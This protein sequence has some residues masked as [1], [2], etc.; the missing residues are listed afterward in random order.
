[1]KDY[2]EFQMFSEGSSVVTKTGIKMNPRV[3]NKT[4]FIYAYEV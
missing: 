3:R 1:M 2:S 4:G